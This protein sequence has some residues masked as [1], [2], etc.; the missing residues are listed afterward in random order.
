LTGSTRLRYIKRVRGLV[1]IPAYNEAQSL[2]GLLQALRR[3]ALAEDVLVVDD[4]SVD[5]TDRLLRESGQKVVRHACNQGYAS[6]IKTGLRYAKE[7]G[8]DYVVT[9]DADGQHDPRAVPRLVEALLRGPADVVIG[10]RFVCDTGYRA[11]LS[12][13]LPMRL[14]SHLTALLG[15]KRIHDTT[16]GFRAL[17]RPAIEVLASQ[18]VGD[19]HAEALLLCLLLGLQVAEVPVQVGPR[20]HGGSM[21][22]LLDMVRYPLRLGLALLLLPVLRHAHKKRLPGPCQA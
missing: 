21:Y 2:P 5:G 1:V 18:P 15:R 20:R 9:L 14:L 3:A 11:P 6:A 16:S 22:G 7:A 8:Y 10:S 19:L 12:R 4:G 13:R 17:R